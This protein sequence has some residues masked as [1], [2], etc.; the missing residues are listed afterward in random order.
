MCVYYSIEFVVFFWLKWHIIDA[1]LERF[2]SAKSSDFLQR[3]LR[4]H[5]RPLTLRLAV[6]VTMALTTVNNTLLP[7]HEY[8]LITVTHRSLSCEDD[9]ALRT[10]F[11]PGISSTWNKNLLGCTFFSFGL[12]PDFWRLFWGERRPFFLSIPTM[13]RLGPRC[14]P[15]VDVPNVYNNTISTF[16]LAYKALILS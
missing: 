11:Q 5:P 14:T 3:P 16:N 6:V 15:R 9:P 1:S 4:R 12:G 10:R 13:A 7:I 2:P 8:C